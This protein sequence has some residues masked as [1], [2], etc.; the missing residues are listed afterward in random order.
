ML[1]N[2]VSEMFMQEVATKMVQAFET[3]CQTLMKERERER[4]KKT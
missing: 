4:E 3:R 2:E 1:Y